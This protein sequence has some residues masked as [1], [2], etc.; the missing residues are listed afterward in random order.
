MDGTTSS[1]NNGGVTVGLTS[2]LTKP[3]Y[4]WNLNFYTGPRT[5]T[6]KRATATSSTPRCCL[7]QRRSS[8]PI[9]TTTT[10][11]TTPPAIPSLG[12]AASASLARHRLRRHEQVTAN[13]RWPDGYEYFDDNQGFATGTAQNVTSSPATYEYKW[14]TGL[15]M[16]GEFRRDWSDVAFFHKGDTSMVKAQST[17]TLGLHR[18]LRPKAITDLDGS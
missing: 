5:T 6:R 13:P 16:R 3:K 4:T 12:S 14:L 2:A 18:L 10:A 7:R 11:R 15:L 1:H 17:A 9:S 8:T